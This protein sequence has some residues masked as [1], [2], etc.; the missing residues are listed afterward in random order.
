MNPTF[1][2]LF[3]PAFNLS[4]NPTRKPSSTLIFWSQTYQPS[5][6]NL[7]YSS[8]SQSPLFGSHIF[9][10]STLHPINNNKISSS[11]FH[12]KLMGVE[13]REGNYL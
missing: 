3:L 4:F 6:L 7:N 11:F 9:P 2:P 5:D 10:P 13:M 1:D 8:S 12:Q